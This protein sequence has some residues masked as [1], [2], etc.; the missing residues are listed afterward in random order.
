MKA[1]VTGAGGFIG[2]HLVER[3]AEGGHQVVAVDVHFPPELTGFDG[4]VDVVTGDFRSEA[5]MRQALT[6]CDVVFH[7]ASAHLQSHLPDS[8]YWDVNVHGLQR[9]LEWSKDAG[10]KRFVHT[11]TVGVYGHIERPPATEETECR[12][13]SIYGQTKLAG[14]RAALQFGKDHGLP[15]VV[16]RPAWVYGLRCRRTERLLRMLKRGR[17][18]KFGPCRNLRHQVYIEDMLDAFELAAQRAEAV[19]EVLIIAD[20]QALTTSELLAAM[21]EVLGVAQPRL[22]LPLPPMKVVAAFA[23]AA[24]KLLQR[25]PPFSR[26]SLE[27]FTTN[28][29]FD[30]SKAQRLLGFAPKYTFRE[31]V[32]ATVEALRV[33][34]GRRHAA[35]V[36][37][38][39]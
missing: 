1:L 31:G 28:N 12:P 18:V 30:I 26:R 22:R 37:A 15:I 25:E 10:V 35:E 2:S 23:E 16:L 24:G 4:K 32:K 38:D 8:E 5:L 3:L 13:Q 6:D 14:E 33:A 39:A 11:S 29:A 19:G 36:V 17:F 27:F 20:E 9:L 34:A 21:C 7:L